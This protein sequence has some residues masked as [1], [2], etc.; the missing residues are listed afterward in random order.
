M[1]SNLILNIEI[2]LPSSNLRLRI[3]Y[4]RFRKKRD[5]LLGKPSFFYGERLVL[6]ASLRAPRAARAFWN[7]SRSKCVCVYMQGNVETLMSVCRC[8]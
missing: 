4:F 6:V 7:V 8:H 5:I 1:R 3:V 2:L